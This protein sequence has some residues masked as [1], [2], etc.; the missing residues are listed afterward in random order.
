MKE[1]QM[2]YFKKMLDLSRVQQRESKRKLA[3]FTVE[4]IDADFFDFD[5][6]EV[7]ELSEQAQSRRARD[8]SF[9]S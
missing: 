4:E 2:S 5:E 8:H 6:I 9:V 1:R 3:Q 7:T